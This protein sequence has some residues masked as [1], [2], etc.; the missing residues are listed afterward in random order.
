MPGKNLI[1]RGLGLTYLHLVVCL[2]SIFLL[3][4]IMLRYLGKEGYG[5]WAVF[6]SITTYLLLYDL[7]INTAIAKYTAEYRASARRERLGQLVSTSLVLLLILAVLVVLACAGAAGFIPALFNVS[8]SLAPE[9]R[10]AFMLVGLNVVVA[11]LGGVFGNVIYGTGRVD[12]WKA[13]SVIQQLANLGLI[14]LFLRL[15]FG[16]VGTIG[17]AV[18]TSL[19]SASLY[20][21]FLH[22]QNERFVISPRLV[23][24]PLLKEIAPYSIR[25]FVLGFTSRVLYYTDYIVI[26]IFLGTAA[27]APYEISYKLCFLATYLFSALSTTLFPTFSSLS[28]KGDLD[29][30]RELYLKTVKM[31]LLIMTVLGIGI[32]LLG[33]SFIGFWVGEGNFVGMPVLVVL[34]IM[35]IFHAIGTPA[36]ALLQGV[37]RNKELMYSEIVNAGL[38]LILSIILARKIGVMG[39]ALATLLAH[40]CTSFWV[41]VLL[42]CRYLRFSLHRYLSSVVLPPLLLGVP[43]G[44]LAWV[45]LQALPQS[46]NLFDLAIKATIVSAIYCVAYLTL[47]AS[48]EERQ[49]YLRLVKGMAPA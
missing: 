48:R 34:V 2:C 33:P 8:D 17:A 10:L 5:L 49:M 45:V 25:T 44:A 16:L 1:L 38:N 18:L 4:P 12:V 6:S 36:A 39:V 43:A 14:V 24:V 47:G 26:G 32:L 11:V 31:S 41:V 19:L 22:I 9:A 23:E 13:I 37:G 35:N 42:P 28:A 15:G 29:G 3:T 40:L 27:V 20:V 7:G 21:L 30:L 46:H